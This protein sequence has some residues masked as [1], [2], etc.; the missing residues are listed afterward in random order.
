MSFFELLENNSPASN[1]NL[2]K[3][4]VKEPAVAEG[5]LYISQSHKPWLTKIE[6]K[7]EKN[8]D[9]FFSSKI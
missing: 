8:G 4:R 1:V 3:I 7:K 6:I 2:A 5:N 9:N